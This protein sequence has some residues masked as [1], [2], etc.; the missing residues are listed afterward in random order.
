MTLS[1]R[2][3]A[4]LEEIPFSGCLADIGTDHGYLPIEAIRRGKC[5]RAIASDVRPGPLKNCREHVAD[6]G[7]SE[8]IE[9]RMGSGLETLTK[10]EA[11]TVVIA[12]MGGDLIAQLLKTSFVK[13]P[14]VLENVRCLIVQPQSEWHKVRHA[15]KDLGFKITSE[16]LTVDRDKTYWMLVCEHGE[17]IY[18][19]DFQY[20]WGRLLAVSKDPMW[21][22]H[23]TWQK[24]MRE[25]VLQSLKDADSPAAVTRKK[26]LRFEI[27]EIEEALSYGT[28]GT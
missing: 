28:E 20:Q 3:E 17:E 6:A 5:H 22:S 19:R 11:D 8:K 16:K 26:I 25:E 4:I 18:D 21:V 1:I 27:E 2:L 7:L 15:L 9:I 24:E 23:L 14:E 13:D 12:G 10:K